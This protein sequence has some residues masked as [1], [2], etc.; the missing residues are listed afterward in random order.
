VSVPEVSLVTYMLGPACA[1][2]GR[3]ENE[4]AYSDAEA[5]DTLFLTWGSFRLWSQRFAAGL[6]AAGLQRGDRV[7]T[8]A[9][10]DVLFPV[11]YTGTCMAGGRFSPANARFLPGELAHQ[12]RVTK[13]R[14]VLA[15]AG[16]V[17][18]A[19]RAVELVGMSRDA[20]FVFDDAPLEREGGGID[21]AERGVRH[22]KHLL[23]SEEVSAGF[24]WDDLDGVAARK[25]TA[26]IVFSSGFVQPLHPFDLQPSPWQ[27]V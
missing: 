11:L 19:V 8:F 18:G 3:H 15:N 21:D 6:V 17:D 13:P 23:A 9:G 14:F 25:T 26:A 27:Y 20:I 24:V 10:N 1:S 16:N 22:W 2:L 5:P 4:L 12:L 7:V